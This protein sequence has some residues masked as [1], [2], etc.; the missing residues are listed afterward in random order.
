MS[1]YQDYPYF[2][3]VGKRG[4]EYTRKAIDL[5]N[6]YNLAYTT[7]YPDSKREIEALKY[8][9]HHFTLPIITIRYPSSEEFVGGADNLEELI[10][11][12]VSNSLS[13]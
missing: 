2:A 9:Y 6:E 12:S 8:H 13:N 11:T 3:I 4:C 5:C 10:A 7:F 1:Y